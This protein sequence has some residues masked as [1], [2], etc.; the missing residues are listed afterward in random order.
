MAAYRKFKRVAIPGLGNSVYSGQKLTKLF[1][2]F[3]LNWK[4]FIHAQAGLLYVIKMMI[5]IIIIV[6]CGMSYSS[7]GHESQQRF[8]QLGISSVWI[9]PT[10]F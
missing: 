6:Y 9:W 2:L 5:I 8:R 3:R 1:P 7:V 4:G 10:C